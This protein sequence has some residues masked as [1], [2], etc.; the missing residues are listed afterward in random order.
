MVEIVAFS[1]DGGAV[2]VAGHGGTARVYDAA[3]G[4]PLSPAWG[5]GV[6]VRAAAFSPDGR[7][8]ATGGSDRSARVW[9]VAT[10]QPVTP[11]LRHDGEILGVSFSPDGR[12]LLSYSLDWTARLWDLVPDDRP[13]ADL[14]LLTQLWA[15]YRLDA[16][17]DLEQL[18]REAQ[19]DALAK[20][21]TGYPAEFTVGPEQVLAWHQ[22]EG[23]KWV[24]MGDSGAALFHYLHAYPIAPEFP[25]LLLRDPQR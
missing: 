17:G 6:R 20:L 8:V 15:G 18:S 13:A 14:V 2:L 24:R 5:H 16:Y 19:T 7:F 12:T 9:D 25:R 4:R 22:H 11:P 21:R 3:T 10:G 23:N 1:P